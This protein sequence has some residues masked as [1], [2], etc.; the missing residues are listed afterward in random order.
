[1]TGPSTRAP[2]SRLAIIRLSSLGDIIHTIP[3]FDR[4]R[5][6]FPAARISWYVEPA[7]AELLAHF[8]G[9]DEIRV[10]RLKQGGPARKVREI[11][12]LKQA[13]E[14]SYDH[15]FDFQGLLKSALISRILP[16]PGHG[17]HRSN[18]REPAARFFYTT[19]VTPFDETRHVIIKNLHL[20][21]A[22]DIHD[23]EIDYPL[24]AL[25]PSETLRGI[26]EWSS[27]D[28]GGYMILNVGGGWDTKILGLDQF[29]DI[30][31]R[32]AG[33]RIFILWG[34]D[35]ERRTAEAVQRRTG[36]EMAPFLTFSDL[37]LFI[38]R[39]RVLIGG[40]TLALHLA[41]MVSTPSVG[42]FGPTSPRR[43]G[44]LL[45]ASRAITAPVACGFCYK[46]KCDKMDCLRAIP[47]P[48]IA[49]S[50]EEIYEKELR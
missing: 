48:L 30:V 11:V 44:S 33:R 19:T 27:E 1:M 2:E 16:G 3:A 15:I 10:V 26:R 13:V 6:H 31:N 36:A 14:T 22:V 4:L 34:N 41:D 5:R 37:I 42:I 40:D 8:Q 25:Q 46:K 29:V 28:H 39:A 17:F 7:G 50:A 49:D 18:L 24:R 21:S 23:A 38:R 43:N 47:T 45:A 9:I 12:R 32:L 35:R 20:L